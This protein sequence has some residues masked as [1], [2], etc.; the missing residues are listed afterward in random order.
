MIINARTHCTVRNILN[1]NSISRLF[2]CIV[3][4]RAIFFFDWL[5]DKR[6]NFFLLLNVWWRNI[7]FSPTVIT[8]SVAQHFN[9]SVDGCRSLNA[10]VVNDVIISDGRTTAMSARRGCSRFSSSSRLNASSNV[11]L[12]FFYK[13]TCVPSC[14]LVIRVR[15]RQ[16]PW[17]FHSDSWCQQGP[18]I[19]QLSWLQRQKKLK[20][21]ER[22]QQQNNN[23]SD[24]ELIYLTRKLRDEVAVVKTFFYKTLENEGKS[25]PST[26]GSA[27]F[28]L[29]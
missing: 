24:E 8:C 18:S 4:D 21:E 3:C 13:V 15:Q 10:V 27:R 6:R 5:T 12:V 17:I 9:W 2:T 19:K 16:T 7:C 23:I 11:F 14:G 20:K 28:Y 29:S 26:Q 25:R 1:E 22:Q